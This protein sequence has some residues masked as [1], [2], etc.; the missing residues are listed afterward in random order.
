MAGDGAGNVGIGHAKSSEVAAAIRKATDIAKK[1]MIRLEVNE[2]TILHPVLGKFSAS[3][4]LLKPA[5]TGSGLIASNA[6]RAVCEAVGIRN[7]L[8]KSLGSHNPTNLACATINALKSIRSVAAI[9]EIRNKPVEYFA[10]KRYEK[11]KSDIKEEP[12]RQDQET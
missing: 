5:Q 2:G 12:D 1:S 9:A 10:R 4:V 7:I 11:T 3:K 8:S 6:V